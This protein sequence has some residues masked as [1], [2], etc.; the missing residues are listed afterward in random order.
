MSF[1]PPKHNLIDSF[2]V[3]TATT[4]DSA[5]FTPRTGHSMLTCYVNSSQDVSVDFMR[6]DYAGAVQSQTDMTPVVVAAGT[7][8]KA[9]FY[10]C[11]GA[12]LIRVMNASGVTAT[13][14]FEAIDGGVA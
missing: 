3:L 8:H 14:R 9:V 2:T 10:E 13:V 4:K 11:V 7:Q 6:L 12:M 1:D 5:P